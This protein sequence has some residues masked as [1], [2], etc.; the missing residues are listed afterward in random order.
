MTSSGDEDTV[1]SLSENM[2]GTRMKNH[3]KHFFCDLHILSLVA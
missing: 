3:A 2:L 1:F